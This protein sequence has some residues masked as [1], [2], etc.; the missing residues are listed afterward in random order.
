MKLFEPHYHTAG[1]SPVHQGRFKS[2][3]VESD[4]HFLVVTRSVERNALRAEL[5]ERA[6]DWRWSSLWRRRR[7]RDKSLAELLAD[8]P[9]PRPADWERRVNRPLTQ[10]ELD[11]VRTR[12]CRGRPCHGALQRGPLMGASNGAT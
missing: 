10:G 7:A 2:F 11:S 3:P 12:V 5:V 6:R 4:E 8:W 1:T 9:V